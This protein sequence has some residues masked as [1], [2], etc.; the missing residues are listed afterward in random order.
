MIKNIWRNYSRYLKIS[1]NETKLSISFGI[2]GAFLETIS[3][4]LL[5]HLITDLS[6]E[7][8]IK[9]IEIIESIVL[10]KE[11]LIILFLISAILSAALYFLSNKNIV[12]AKC[13]IE[14][15]VRQEITDLTL[16]IKWEYYLQM[17][18]GDISKSIISEG[19]NIS[20]GYMY[21]LSALTYSLIACTYLLAC[22]ILVPNTL[23]ILLIYSLF[24][25]RIYL[26]YS[27]KANYFGK[28]LSQ[29]TS[30]IGRWTSSIFSNL[31]YLRAISKDS[32]A[33]EESNIIFKK[34]ANS[35]ENAM[36]ASYKSK[37]ITEL[38][39]ITFIVLSIF[40]IIISGSNTSNLILSLSLFIRM[41][42]KVYNAQSR[43][44]DSLA[45]VSW[46]KSHHEKINWA[47][48]FSDS[49]YK[50]KKLFKFN[51]RISFKSV[52]F[53]YPNSNKILKDLNLSIKKNECI[54]ITG[55]SGIGKSTVLDL[56]TGIIKP[57]GGSIFLSGENINSINMNSWRE[58]IGIVMQ[59]N[60]FK[61]DTI[62]A[63]IALG[64]KID[65]KKIN[66][67]LIKA[68]AWDFVNS[69]SKGI[70]ELIFDRG[71]RFSGGER[72]RLSLARALYLDPKIL[73]LDE[74]STGLDKIS[75]TELI[76]SIKKI[77]GTMTII[78]I[79]HKKSILNISD[80]VLE[81]K[82]EGLKEL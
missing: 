7:R 58:N 16:K 55:K 23:F 25:F 20:E 76:S 31:K 48:N 40:F 1:N 42:P 3:I 44:L 27:R 10:S 37:F 29:I 57:T 15:F 59:E 73:L 50:N 8:T 30:N 64:K 49:I 52:N 6:Y 69:L 77:K 35:Y 14:R 74:P 21:F 43:L 60:F 38:L 78:I 34:F 75:E 67:S 51:G 56:I 17:S 65:R 22:L 62:A 45:M 61:N 4:Y 26:H 80:R 41:T 71:A 18:Q 32:L 46:P 5:A 24:T 36:V 63:N 53:Q 28:D 12:K 70:D 47:K 11:N 33:K 13:K 82:N 79:S 39:T 72:Q 81:L 54:G 19:Q 66:S 9:K 2:I 68:N